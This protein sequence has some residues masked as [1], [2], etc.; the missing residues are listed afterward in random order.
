MGDDL[1]EAWGADGLGSSGDEGTSAAA[2]GDAKNNKN[3]AQL[4]GY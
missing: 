1:G 3:A 2:A 4:K